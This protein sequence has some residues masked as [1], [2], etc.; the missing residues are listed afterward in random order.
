MNTNALSMLGFT[1]S[2]F[3]PAAAPRDT[4]S[5]SVRSFP[6]IIVSICVHS[7]YSR[8][9]L[10]KANLP[11]LHVKHGDKCSHTLAEIPKEW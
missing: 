6:P 10:T 2:S 3:H 5:S 9:E 7:R 4:N 1:V 11:H 8:Y